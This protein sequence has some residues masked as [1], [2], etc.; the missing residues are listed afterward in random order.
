M[1]Q[2]NQ[3]ILIRY[4]EIF[5]KSRFV[6]SQFEKKL[7]ENISRHLKTA[8]INF[9]LKKERG[10]IFISI[11]QKDETI[12]FERLKKVFG[13]VS[14]SPTEHLKT[15]KLAEIKK[16][17]RRNFK[18]FVK[19][20]ETFAVRAKRAGQ[21]PFSSKDL[22]N[23][24]GAAI[25][26]KVNLKNPKKEIFVEV[27]EK[28]TYVF[29]EVIPGPGGLPLS[30][31]G[32]VISLI[33]GGIDSPAASYLAMKRGCRVIFLHFHSF[34]LVSKKSIE[35]SKEIVKKLNDYQIKSKVILFPFQKIQLKFKTEAPAKYLIL[36]YRRSM[37]RL[38]QKLA[39]EE[40]AEGIFT[41]ESLAQV[42]SQTLT[43]L[44]VIEEA[45]KIPI[46][47]PVIGLDKEE[48]IALAK[49]IGTYDISILPQEDCCTLFVPQH[50]ATRANLAVIKSI[51][52]KTNIKKLEKILF[53]EKEE[54]F[55]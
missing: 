45:V 3:V 18:G 47:R 14:F 38:G 5:L 7:I 9:G 33:S 35:K 16:F 30:T 13:I 25:R 55:I 28:D 42:S 22:E 36:L 11:D 54:I 48:I 39:K 6:F 10:R 24:V 41:G 12:V 4:G 2:I 52:E 19:K 51:E 15:T 44:G 40:D 20:G 37:M 8:G 21:H 23:E 31:A 27:R 49:K 1:K 34:P 50:P 29:T 43:N 32:K 17:C 26:G 53:K 46:F